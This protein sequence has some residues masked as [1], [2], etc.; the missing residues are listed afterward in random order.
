MQ[1]ISRVQYSEQALKMFQSEIDK[2]GAL[3]TGGVLIGYIK[4]D[5]IMIEKASN[6]GPN[7]IHE[8][9]YF[10]ADPHYIDMFIDMEIA[11]SSG[12]IRYIG[13][14]H[15]HPQVEPEP[16]D[17]DLNSLCEIAE[18]ANDFCM[19]LIIGAV[20]FLPQLFF[21]QSITI[22]KYKKSDNSKL[23]NLIQ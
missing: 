19:L 20:E 1:Q 21:N 11:N 8:E 7:A 13:E 10:R 22:I 4:D 23:M 14:W 9:F 12:E 16:S 15:T 2:L 18:S 17:L 3:E 5:L 6:G